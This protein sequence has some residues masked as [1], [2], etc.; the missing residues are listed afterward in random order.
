M[1]SDQER[2]IRKQ[3][4]YQTIYY[5]EDYMGNTDY[6]YLITT[7]TGC[8]SGGRMPFITIENE[9]HL[10]LKKLRKIEIILSKAKNEEEFISLILKHYDKD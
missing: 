3:H 1:I 10:R 6:T 4:I 5:E 7:S 8:K 2:L 9:R